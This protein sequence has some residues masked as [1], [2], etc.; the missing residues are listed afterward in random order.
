MRVVDTIAD[1]LLSRLDEMASDERGATLDD[2]GKL[3]TLGYESAARHA[4]PQGG[5]GPQQGQ[6]ESQSYDQGA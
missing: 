6:Q 4:D 3:E 2:S 1:D 5:E